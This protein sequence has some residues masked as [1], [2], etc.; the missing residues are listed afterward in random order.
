M[1]GLTRLGVAKRVAAATALGGGGIGVL[2]GGA[3]GLIV[4]EAKLAR[5]AIGP[6]RAIRRAR[7]ASTA[8]GTR[9]AGSK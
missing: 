7:T 8:P 5:R 1:T 3:I 6:R 9:R 4:A 2:T